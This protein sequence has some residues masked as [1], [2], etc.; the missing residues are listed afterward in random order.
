MTVFFVS[1]CIIAL[2]VTDERQRG[3]LPPWQSKCENRTATLSDI[4]VL[5]F[6]WVSVGCC[7]LRFSDYFLV[8][9]GFSIAVHTGLTIISQVFFPSVG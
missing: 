9:Y 8:I 6:V 1:P 4:S 3:E 7:F 2:D 5:V